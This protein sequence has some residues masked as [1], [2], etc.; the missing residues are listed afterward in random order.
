M[1]LSLQHTGDELRLW[2]SLGARLH[3]GPNYCVDMRQESKAG[4]FLGEWDVG[5]RQVDKLAEQFAARR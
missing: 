1:I 2:C 5:L 3:P 4:T